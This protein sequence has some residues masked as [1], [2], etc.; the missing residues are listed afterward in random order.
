MTATQSLF[1]DNGL[2][3]VVGV[4]MLYDSLAQTL[5]KI[6]CGPGVSRIMCPEVV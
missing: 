6:G 4:E 5:K 2:I 3:G 1:M